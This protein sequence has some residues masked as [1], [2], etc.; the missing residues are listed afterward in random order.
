ME[1]KI[2]YVLFSTIIVLLLIETNVNTR[3]NKQVPKVKRIDKFIQNTT[4][5]KVYY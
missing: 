2:S 1:D 5:S 4:L 3:T